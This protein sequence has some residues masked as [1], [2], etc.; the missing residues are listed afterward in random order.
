M[1]IL[2]TT[3]SFDRNAA[4]SLQLLEQAGFEI[5]LNPHARRLNEA[6]AGTLLEG[7]F[8]GM[9]AGVEPLTRKVLCGAK[10][11]K[12]ISRCGIGLD[13][14]DLEAANELG[15]KVFNT[16]DAPSLP[17]AELTLG[18]MLNLLRRVSEA[19]REIRRN[20]W[21]PL[22][23]GLLSGRTVG[24]IGFG[25]IG[26]KVAQLVQAFGAKVMVYDISPPASTTGVASCSLDSLL[27]ESDIV[28]LH[29]PYT[30]A[31]RHLLNAARIASM[32]PGAILI[33]ASRGGLIDETA[34][35]EALNE[36]RL[37]GAGLDAFEQEPYAGPLTALPQVLLT[38]HMGSYASEAR[39]RMEAEAA[40]NLVRG[41]VD[42]GLL[43]PDALRRIEG[44]N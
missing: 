23:G 5:I 37:A 42:C 28:S 19:D 39:A 16:P 35:L 18:L 20:N 33:N 26:K 15:I 41:L 8:V 17:V 4:A 7:G 14:V 32:K 36:G 2:T 40:D 44:E 12:I 38:A 3:S 22:M 6:E 31:N 13:S 43:P 29:L 30:A 10:G 27:E 1:K 34:L 25:R 21:R 11:L 24:L 9:I